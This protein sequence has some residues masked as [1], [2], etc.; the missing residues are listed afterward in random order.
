[1]GSGNQASFD[2]YASARAVLLAFVDAYP[3]QL[4][5]CDVTDC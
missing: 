2:I 5:S 4:A 3:A 1:M